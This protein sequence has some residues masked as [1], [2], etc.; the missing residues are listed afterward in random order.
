MKK[1]AASSILVAVMLLGVAVMAEA[2]QPKIYRVGVITARGTRRLTD[3][4]WD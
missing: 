4:G 3:C 1:A 2:Q